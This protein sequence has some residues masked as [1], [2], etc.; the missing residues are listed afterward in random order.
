MWFVEISMHRFFEVV[1]CRIFVQHNK[2]YWSQA[3]E[4]RVRFEL[5]GPGVFGFTGPPRRP[6]ERLWVDPD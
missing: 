5:R 1:S 3:R 4:A 2:K 6:A